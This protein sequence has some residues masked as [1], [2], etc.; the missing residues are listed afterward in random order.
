[1]KK[2]LLLLLIF[3]SF[4]CETESEEE[5]GGT[6]SG[7]AATYSVMERT[8]SFDS[9]LISDTDESNTA[10]HFTQEDNNT[11]DEVRLT[12][13]TSSDYTSSNPI[14]LIIEGW[15]G[16]QKPGMY[17]T[18]INT[19][20]IEGNITQDTRINLIQNDLLNVFTYSRCNIDLSLY[21]NLFNGVILQ[22][23]YPI[24]EEL[25]LHE[26]PHESVYSLNLH[27]MTGNYYYK[28]V[29]GRPDDNT[30]QWINIIEKL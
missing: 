11:M 13:D 30:G 21:P 14:D 22:E 7:V 27:L 4:S 29:I 2:S 28:E 26:H 5:G 3:I 24:G 10:I 6:T 15:G 16:N 25:L 9:V 8:T 12:I 20:T 17:D 19:L 1:M 23:G 18:H